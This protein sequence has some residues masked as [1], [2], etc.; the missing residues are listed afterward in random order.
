MVDDKKKDEIILR[1]ETPYP[2]NE[3]N[4]LVKI[5]VDLIESWFQKIVSQAIQSD[6]KHILFN[7]ITIFFGNFFY[8]LVAT[9]TYFPIQELILKSNGCLDESIGNITTPKVPLSFKKVRVG[10]SYMYIFLF[11]V[12]Q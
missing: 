4:I 1:L 12:A 11:N 5:K 10:R 3:H 6:V 9:S 8:H 2:I 7:L